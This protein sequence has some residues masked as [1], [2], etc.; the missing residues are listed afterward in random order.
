MQTSIRMVLIERIFC[1][2]FTSARREENQINI[3][4]R[5]AKFLEGDFKGKFWRKLLLGTKI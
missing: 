4:R 1:T 3:R 5:F 2:R